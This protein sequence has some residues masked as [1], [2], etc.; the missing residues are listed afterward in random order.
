[1]RKA[2][3]HTI[4]VDKSQKDVEALERFEIL[5]KITDDDWTMYKL[6]IASKRFL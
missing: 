4:I 2:I 5:S 6:S 1:M 3:Y